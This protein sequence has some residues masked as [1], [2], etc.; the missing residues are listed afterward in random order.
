MAD[1]TINHHSLGSFPAVSLAGELDAYH[2]PRL[3]DALDS[4]L[5][6]PSVTLIVDLRNVTY[7]DSTGLGVLVAVRKRA[8]TQGGG[9]RLIV[10]SEGAVQRTLTITGL[11]SVFPIF[12]D[13]ASAQGAPVHDGKDG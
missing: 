12:S 1:L 2:A 5:A 4:L 7:I 6:T 8:D 13:E 9:I 11:L 10:T 3:R